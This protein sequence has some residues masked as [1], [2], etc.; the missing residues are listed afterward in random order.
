LVVVVVVVAPRPPA[1]D[2]KTAVVEEHGADCRFLQ[3][4]TAHQVDCVIPLAWHLWGGVSNDGIDGGRVEMLTAIYTACTLHT[5]AD[6]ALFLAVVTIII[7]E[8]P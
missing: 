7:D 2:L 1:D 8:G 6:R 5:L 4:V 3:R